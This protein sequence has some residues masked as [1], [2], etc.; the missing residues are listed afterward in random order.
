M[1]RNRNDYDFGGWATRYNV[2]CKDGLTIRRDAFLDNDG[3]T[4]PLVWMHQHGD[5]L[6]VLGHADLE[7]R[8][9]GIYAWGK[10]NSSPEGQGAKQRML[11]GDIRHLSIWANELRK[12]SDLKNVVHGAIKEVSLVLAGANPGAY[13]ETMAIAHSDGSFE[14]FED[15]AAIYSDDEFKIEVFDHLAHADD[16]G[17]DDGDTQTAS[18]DFDPEAVFASM[19]EDQKNLLY[20]VTGKAAEDA[21]N[22]AIDNVT[23]FQHS[24]IGGEEMYQNVFE[25]GSAQTSN[26]LSHDDMNVILDDAQRCGSLREAI[27]AH[28]E[29]GVLAHADID[30]TG[31]TLPTGQNPG[32]GVYSMDMLFPEYKS[33]NTPPEFISR[34]MSW[35]SKLMGRVHHTPF[36]RIKSMYADITEDEARA[37][38]YIKG[39]EK[40]TEVFS[41]MSRTTDPQT[42]YKLQ[43]FDHDDIKDITDFDVIAWVRREMRMMLDEEIARAILIGDGRLVTDRFHIKEDHIRPIVNDANLYTIKQKVPF[44]AGATGAQKAKAMIEYSIRSRKNYKGSGN[45]ILFTTEDW[46]TEMLLL[47][48]GFSH[49]LYKTEGELATAMRV[50]DIVTVEVMEGFQRKGDDNVTRDVMGIIVNPADYNVGADKGGSIENFEDFDIKYNQHYYLLETRFSGALTKPFSA[51]VLEADPAT[52]NEVVVG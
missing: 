10:F 9:E 48:D 44:A 37:K 18:G 6:N 39:D 22:E 28:R 46:L 11:D 21:A 32:Y 16:D 31:M 8:P 7:S 49:R 34:D 50:S 41:I 42:V 12:T 27:K 36:S 4:V 25:R 15:Q 33:L 23:S 29:R 47:E 45:P 26:V 43:K 3:T 13:I 19:N 20:L 2:E 35:V 51:I 38:G 14:T 30:T 1:K 52:G 40:F 5:V 17:D 24:Y